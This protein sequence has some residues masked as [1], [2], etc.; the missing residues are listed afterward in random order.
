MIEKHIFQTKNECIDHLN[1]LFEKKENRNI[2]KV[3]EI[4]D[5]FISHNKE[6]HDFFTSE[7][8]KLLSAF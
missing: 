8:K 3:N 6:L 1:L 4:A 5:R 2:S 7:A